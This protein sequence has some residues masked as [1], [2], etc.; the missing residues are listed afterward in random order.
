MKTN[1]RKQAGLGT[2][3]AWDPGTSNLYLKLSRDQIPRV[4][5]PR[6]NKLFCE[7]G[8]GDLHSQSIKSIRSIGQSKHLPTG[9]KQKP[10]P[11][12]RSFVQSRGGGSS[13]WDSVLSEQP[14]AKAGSSEEPLNKQGNALMLKSIFQP[15]GSSAAVTPIS[16]GHHGLFSAQLWRDANHEPGRSCVCPSQ[17]SL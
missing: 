13:A 1:A 5:R 6:S 12:P 7:G 8:A 15:L 17:N 16:C 10:A 3:P 2:T 4:D 9:T 14:S 11:S